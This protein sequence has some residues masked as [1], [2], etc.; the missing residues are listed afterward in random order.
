MRI[1]RRNRTPQKVENGG[2]VSIAGLGATKKIIIVIEQGVG[3]P[4]FACA[5]L[6]IV[7]ERFDARGG[8]VRIFPQIEV[9][10]EE[11]LQASAMRQRYH[12]IF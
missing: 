12:K 8:H 9:P 4:S 3:L 7:A 1:P 10:I 6:E 2:L 5:V 11:P